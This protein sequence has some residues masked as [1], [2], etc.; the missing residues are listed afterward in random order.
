M[1]EASL[2]VC[3]YVYEDDSQVSTCVAHH[4]I[5]QLMVLYPQLLDPTAIRRC[6]ARLLHDVT[7]IS[8]ADLQRLGLVELV[9]AGWPY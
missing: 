6:F 1:L 8:E 7:L 5:H 9:I 4:H 2:M 3:Q